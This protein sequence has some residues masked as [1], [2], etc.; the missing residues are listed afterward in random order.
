MTTSYREED[1]STSDNVTYLN[2]IV[3]CSYSYRENHH[4]L[5]AKLSRKYSMSYNIT[6][7]PY[8]H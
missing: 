7:Q 8:R 3:T 5:F 4:S 6:K 2:L 1:G